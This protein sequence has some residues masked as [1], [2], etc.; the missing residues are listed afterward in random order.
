MALVGSDAATILGKNPYKSNVDLWEEKTR[1]KEAPDI[2]DKP[3][4]KYRTRSRRTSK[5]FIC[6]RLS[7]I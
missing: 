4:V 7:K 5:E 3:Y 6:I 1:R 2:S